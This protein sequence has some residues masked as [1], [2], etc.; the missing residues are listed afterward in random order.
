MARST[1]AEVTMIISKLARL[2]ERARL[3]IE[4]LL[5]GEREARE[6]ERAE[7]RPQKDTNEKI[8]GTA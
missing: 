3:A 7:Q 8:G 4:N 6:R 1:M 5:R 2:D